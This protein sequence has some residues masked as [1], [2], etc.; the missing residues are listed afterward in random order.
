MTTDGFTILSPA[1][2][3]MNVGVSAPTVNGLGTYG[4]VVVT[5][6]LPG[7][8]FQAAGRGQNILAPGCLMGASGAIQVRYLTGAAG[9]GRVVCALGTADGSAFIA[10]SVDTLNRPFATITDN[11]GTTVAESQG[12]G[13]TI[14]AG[15]Q[16]T[17]TV[18]W[19]SS[20]LVPGAGGYYAA[21]KHDG[22]VFDSGAWS[23]VPSAIWN[24]FVPATMFMGYRPGATEFNGTVLKVQ[25]GNL[26][27]I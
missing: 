12:L 18:T 16:V 5:E 21:A 9:T 15:E 26:P 3:H 19:D 1:G 20:E 27:G 10:V 25:A 23:T 13:L 8:K 14:P 17:F 7:G 22:D 24:S 2:Y 6:P 4:P 11:A